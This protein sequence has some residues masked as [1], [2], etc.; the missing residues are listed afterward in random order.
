MAVFLDASF[1]MAAADTSDLNH[2]A[3]VR[4]LARNEEPLLVGALSL[5]D[6]DAVL[7]RGLGPD[8]TLALLAAISDGAVRVASPT[9][10]DLDRAAA[11]MREAAAHRPRLVDATLVATMDRLGV[12]RIA[13][14]ERRPLAVLRPADRPL[15]LEP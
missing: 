12:G 13:T 11:L 9:Q 14:F 2:A 15:T 3:A 4:W 1:I 7:Q 10:D 8:G 6:A 5:A